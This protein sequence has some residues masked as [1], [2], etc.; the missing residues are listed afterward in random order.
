MFFFLKDKRVINF[1]VF[2]TVLGFSFGFHTAVRTVALIMLVVGIVLEFFPINRQTISRKGVNLLV[3]ILFCFISFG[4]RLL[5]ITKD[6]FFAK[7][8]FYT[9]FNGKENFIGKFDE[10]SQRYYHSLLSWSVEP[11]Q[12][13][14]VDNK[15]ILTPLLSVF[16]IVGLAVSVFVWNNL[17]LK[18]ISLLALIIPFSNSA[19]TDALNQGHWL[20]VLLPIGAILIAVGIIVFQQKMSKKLIKNIFSFLVLIYLLSQVFFFFLQTAD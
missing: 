2:G 16:F 12:N 11:L 14:T 9:Q 10:M 8:R 15:P 17:Y 18:I 7:H 19:L 1:A 6:V 4:P 20:S 3:F 13:R 5:F